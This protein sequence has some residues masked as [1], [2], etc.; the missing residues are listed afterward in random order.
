MLRMLTLPRFLLKRSDGFEARR[1][2]S[3]IPS[4]SACRFDAED[5][6]EK[7]DRFVEAGG[8]RVDLSLSRFDPPER[9]KFNPRIDLRPFFSSLT[10]LSAT[11]D[12]VAWAEAG[13]IE[14]LDD[15][16]EKNGIPDGVRRGLIRLD[17]ERPGLVVTTAGVLIDVE[18][19][20]CWFAVRAVPELLCDDVR[21]L[22]IIEALSLLTLLRPSEPVVLIEY[23]L[24]LLARLAMSLV[25]DAI[26]FGS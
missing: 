6:V 20:S 10:V 3:S 15:L 17:R 8:D 5:E 7:V 13:S 9:R 19:A 1:R 23:S 24:L 21:A 22:A 14:L 16:R 26:R 11:G 25:D 12:G 2:N 4:E 18:D